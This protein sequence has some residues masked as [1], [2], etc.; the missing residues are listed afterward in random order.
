ML[1]GTGPGCRVTTHEGGGKRMRTHLREN[2]HPMCQNGGADTAR[3]H[4]GIPQL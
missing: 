2:G 1:F 3:V 4:P